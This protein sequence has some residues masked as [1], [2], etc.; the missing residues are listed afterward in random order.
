MPRDPYEILG[1]AKNASG[2]KIKKAYRKLAKTSHP[3]LHPGDDKA[4]RH[5]KEISQAYGL[6]G[7][8]EKRVRYDNG[9]IDTDGKERPRSP[10]PGQDA[11]GLGR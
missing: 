2:D 6:L 10:F 4:E 9:E 7:D 8:A 11:G 1:V 3:D 5:F